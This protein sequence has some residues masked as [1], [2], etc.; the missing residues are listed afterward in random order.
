MLLWDLLIYFLL[1]KQGEWEQTTGQFH[2]VTWKLT[3]SSMLTYVFLGRSKSWC[4]THLF[5][6]GSLQ[7]SN[8]V[9]LRYAKS[10]GK[11]PDMAGLQVVS[12]GDVSPGNCLHVSGSSQCPNP[13]YKPKSMHYKKK[14][15]YIYFEIL[16]NMLKYQKPV[17]WNPQQ[18]PISP[19]FNGTFFHQLEVGCNI[20]HTTFKDNFG[21]WRFV[22]QDVQVF[23]VPAGC[24]PA[25]H[26]ME[27]TTP[28]HAVNQNTRLN[29]LMFWPL[30]HY[31]PTSLSNQFA[32]IKCNFVPNKETAHSFVSTNPNA[33]R[34]LSG[35]CRPQQKLSRFV[36]K[37]TP[38]KL[39]VK[40]ILGHVSS[41]FNH[42]LVP[43]Q[44]VLGSGQ[45]VCEIYIYILINPH[46]MI[47]NRIPGLLGLIHPYWWCLKGISTGIGCQIWFVCSNSRNAW[48]VRT[49]C[50]PAEYASSIFV[51]LV[52]ERN[53]LTKGDMSFSIPFMYRYPFL[54]NQKF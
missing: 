12:V 35:Y 15:I 28:R 46:H 13:Y 33:C 17:T 5:H 53:Q 52:V 29:Y 23:Q 21:S 10:R 7:P 22:N 37:V 36:G 44:E 30:L 48:S 4:P 34:K 47:L 45:T 54:S 39:R 32:G 43:S 8:P 19:E 14:Y 27:R 40:C 51:N 38:S 2:F 25:K 11:A 16:R 9:T 50:T 6:Q 18:S 31:L 20:F 41:G 49:S 42:S 26:L 1:W 24:F 3:M